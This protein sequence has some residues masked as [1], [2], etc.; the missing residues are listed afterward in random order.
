MRAKSRNKWQGNLILFVALAS[1][2]LAVFS[3]FILTH[4]SYPQRNCQA[5]YEK[6]FMPLANN[7]IN[8]T[9]GL[10][11]PAH[12]DPAIVYTIEQR[13]SLAQAFDY[14]QDKDYSFAYSFFH[15]AMEPEEMKAYPKLMLFYALTA[16]AQDEDAEASYCLFFLEE[17]GTDFEYSDEVRWYLALS[18][19]KQCDLSEAKALLK[20]LRQTAKQERYKVK[21][22]QLVEEL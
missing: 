11:Y 2:G 20:E 13:R 12:E 19:I 6:Y 21:A 5:I 10:P 15:K 16:L 9:D 1:A 17:L 8:P 22:A 4:S 18:H 7:Y 14:Y 3:F